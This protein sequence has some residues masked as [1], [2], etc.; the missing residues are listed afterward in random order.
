MCCPRDSVWGRNPVVKRR[1]DLPAIHEHSVQLPLRCGSV[2]RF[3]ILDEA[4]APAVPTGRG[5][6]SVRAVQRGGGVRRV[7]SQGVALTVRICLQG[8]MVR[9]IGCTSLQCRWGGSRG[10]QVRFWDGEVGGT[11]IGKSQ[12]GCAAGK[13]CRLAGLSSTNC[14]DFASV[15]SRN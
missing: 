10:M 6:R 8:S 3:R 1:T 4:D 11:L 12:D 2:L 5:R 9:V 7:P 15:L 14:G 13:I